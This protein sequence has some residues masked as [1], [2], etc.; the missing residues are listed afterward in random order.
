MTARAATRQLWNACLKGNLHKA[1]L[2]LAAGADKE[3]KGKVGGLVGFIVC[4][5]EYWMLVML[6]LQLVRRLE[7]RSSSG[8]A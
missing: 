2:A 4:T 5:R 6:L 8:P 3:A 7:A 1:N